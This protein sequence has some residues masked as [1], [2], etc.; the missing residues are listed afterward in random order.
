MELQDKNKCKNLWELFVG[1]AF[2]VFT[3][4]LQ[5]YKYT[6]YGRLFFALNGLIFGAPNTSLQ[7]SD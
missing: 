3:L 6:V 1:Y 5:L 4:V 7:L 2:V